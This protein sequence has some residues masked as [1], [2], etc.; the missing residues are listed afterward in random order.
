MNFNLFDD[1]H[2]SE[3][4]LFRSTTEELINLYGVPIKYIITKKINQDNI[5]GEHSHIKVDNTSVFEMFAL[6]SSTDMWEGDNSLFSK[7]GM[8]SLDSLSIFISR[9]DFEI[10][11][12]EI[13]NLEGKATIDNVPNGNLVVFNSNKIMEVTDFKLAT[14]D[15]NRNNIFTSDRE[16]NVYK[17]TLKTYINNHDNTTEALDITTS[18]HF[19]YQDFGNLEDIFGVAE[20]AKEEIEERSQETEINNVYPSTPREKPIRVKENSVFGEFG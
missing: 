18:E 4:N 3:Y 20:D 17:L 12:P 5:F 8:N 14:D 13:A 10:I 7:F 16:K 11:H 1:T 2:N 6:P 19:D 9:T 15:H